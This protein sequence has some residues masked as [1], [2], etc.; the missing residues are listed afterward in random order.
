MSMNIL[1]EACDG[2]AY[3]YDC[4][5]TCGHCRDVEQCYNINGT[6]LTGCEPDYQG[7]LCK[8]RE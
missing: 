4:R 2:G 1:F 7:D 6:C 8:T 5:E 3:G